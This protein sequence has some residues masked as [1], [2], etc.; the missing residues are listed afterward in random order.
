MRGVLGERKGLLL[1]N[2]FHA[3]PNQL[4]NF[5]NADHRNAY[6]EAGKTAQIGNQT[7]QLKGICSNFNDSFRSLHYRPHFQSASDN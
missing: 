2:V 3:E 6:P 4:H 7:G 5:Q 1:V